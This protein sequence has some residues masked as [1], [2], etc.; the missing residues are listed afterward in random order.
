MIVD[1]HIH[2]KYSGDSIIEP[3]AIVKIA[4]K[5]GL[6][7]IAVTDHLTIKGGVEALA[8]N[9]DPDLLVIVGS[10][11]ETLHKADV[12]GL[13]LTEEIKSRGTIEVIEEI[14]AQGGVAFWAHP[15]REGKRLLPPSLI[16]HVDLIEGFN[17]KTSA[18]RNR[19]AQD[20]AY[21]YKKP[22][23][24]TSDA[25]HASEIGNG[26][27]LVRAPNASAVKDALAQ[28][29]TAIVDSKLSYEYLYDVSS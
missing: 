4:K 10:E 17:S 21:Q 18:S 24:G 1:F 5:K 28:G 25:H 22:L 2:S 23:I 7:G 26:K 3:A 19:L 13:F 12:V 9:T 6:N 15:F 11:I 27:T 14:R 20:L 16:H 8:L 29:K